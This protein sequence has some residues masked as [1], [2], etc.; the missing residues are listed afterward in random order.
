MA[1]ND[2]RPASLPLDAKDV[3]EIL[4]KSRSIK[5]M[6]DKAISVVRKRAE[7]LHPR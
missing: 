4:S 7:R 3:E 5:E 6:L 1:A 2:N